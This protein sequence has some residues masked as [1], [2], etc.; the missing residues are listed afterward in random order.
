LLADETHDALQDHLE[1]IAKDQPVAM[2][3]NTVLQLLAGLAA[4]LPLPVLAQLERGSLDGM[5]SKE[6]KAFIRSCG[7]GSE[8]PK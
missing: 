3:E 8:W 6:T 1:Q 2:F 5:G 4:S 7:L